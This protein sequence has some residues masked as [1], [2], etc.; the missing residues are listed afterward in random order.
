MF[1]PGEPETGFVG[2]ARRNGRAR[3]FVE[4]T[5]CYARAGSKTRSAFSAFLLCCSLGSFLFYDRVYFCMTD[6]IFSKTGICLS[7]FFQKFF[8]LLFF[9]FLFFLNCIFLWCI[10]ARNLLRAVLVHFSVL[11][12]DQL[13]PLNQQPYLQI[14]CQPAQNLWST[15]LL[16]QLLHGHFSP[17]YFRL[18]RNCWQTA[19]AKKT[20]QISPA[21]VPFRVHRCSTAMAGTPLPAVDQPVLA[22]STPDQDRTRCAA[23]YNADSAI[24]QNSFCSSM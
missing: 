4:A 18:W 12:W 9:F 21:I 7:S 3:Q 13:S 14:F 1:L 22:T 8:F 16:R 17:E 20:Q 19:D 6:N 11:F 15:S 24:K 2:H 23:T 5:A 10:F